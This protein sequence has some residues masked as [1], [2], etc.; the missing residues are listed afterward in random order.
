MINTILFDLDGTLLPMNFDKFMELYF[1]NLGKYLEEYIDPNK[2]SDIIMDCTTVMVKNTEHIINQDVF[3]KR[4][5]ELVGG[6]ESFLL[7]K[8]HDFYNS[9]FD[10]VK[11]STWRNQDMIESIKILKQ[12]GYKI[13]LATNPLF[14][15]IANYHRIE[16]AGFKPSDFDY[17]SSFE[18]NMYCKPN[19]EYYQEVLSKV[20]KQPNECMMVGNDVLEDL[21][22]GKLGLETFLI[23]ECMINRYHLKIKADH[24]G[25]Y[26]HFYDFAIKMN[27]IK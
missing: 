24:I 21:V 11:A 9:E 17:I 23:E 8:F 25:S 2:I 12:K 3:M 27:C 22:A 4:F 1:K 13:V 26:K 19:L 6:E 15:M 20:N 7:S 16:W 18:N 5:K 14:P 10:K